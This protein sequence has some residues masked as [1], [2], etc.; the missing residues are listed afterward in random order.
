MTRGEK[1]VPAKSLRELLAACSVGRT[2]NHKSGGTV[3]K[4]SIS[5]C[6]NIKVQTSQL[7]RDRVR[8]R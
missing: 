6:A 2:G 8:K 1:G 7:R 3:E 5:P 4:G